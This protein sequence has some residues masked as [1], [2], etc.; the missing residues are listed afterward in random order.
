MSV[1]KQFECTHCGA[2]GKISIKGTDHV[3]EDVV[4]CPICGSDIFEEEDVDFDSE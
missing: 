1:V 3:F 4:C 2:E